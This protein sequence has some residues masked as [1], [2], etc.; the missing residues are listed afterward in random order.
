MGKKLLIKIK[1]YRRI[2]KDEESTEDK[3][4]VR[5]EFLEALCQ[6]VI[7]NTLAEYKGS[8]GKHE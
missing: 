8:L 3:I 7:R 6:N 5:V 1:E 4:K 2:M